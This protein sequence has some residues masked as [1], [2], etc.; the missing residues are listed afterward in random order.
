MPFSIT[1]TVYMSTPC[2]RIMYSNGITLRGS[3]INSINFIHPFTYHITKS[4]QFT[5]V[6]SVAISADA[7]MVACSL[8]SNPWASQ[9]EPDVQEVVRIWTLDPD[10]DLL[11]LHHLRDLTGHHTSCISGVA[12]RSD[13]RCEAVW[14]FRCKYG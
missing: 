11:D 3:D 1:C 4:I 14:L 2:I 10:L 12:W 9:P 5:V 8:G 13:N 7:S 6:Q